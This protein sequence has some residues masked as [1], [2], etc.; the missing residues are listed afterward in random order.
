MLEE[1]SSKSQILTFF[2][3]LFYFTSD[4]M[5]LSCVKYVIFAKS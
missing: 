4:I 1:M 2:N 3:L 5:K